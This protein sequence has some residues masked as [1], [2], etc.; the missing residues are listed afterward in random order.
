MYVSETQ[1]IRPIVKDYC[2]GSVVD[3]GCGDDII[4]SHALG[5]DVRQTSKSK[6]V[7]DKFK[8]LST[9]LN[10]KFDTV[11]SSHCLEHIDNDLD[12]LKDWVHLLNDGGY[13]ILY[14]PDENFYDNSKNPDHLHWYNH[15]SFVSWFESNFQEMK[16]INHGLDVGE[17]RYSFFLI[18][19]K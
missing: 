2:N 19:K 15:K 12:A 14:L 16:I 10:Q 5:V 6:F 13:L 3:I 11:F 17:D 4:V 1:K 7:T 18:A 9:V 8:T